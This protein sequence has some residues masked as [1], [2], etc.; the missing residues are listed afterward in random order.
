MTLELDPR[1]L[2][3]KIDTAETPVVPEEPLSFVYEIT[4]QVVTHD[5]DDRETI[6]GKFLV[7][8]VDADAVMAGKYCSY[9][10]MMD[11]RSETVGYYEYLYGRN[12]GVSEELERLLGEEPINQNA[13]ILDRLEIL[14]QYRGKKIAVFVLRRLIE[15]FASSVGIVA[16]K[17]FPLQFEASPEEDDWRQSLK[18]DELPKNETRSVAK[19]RWYYAALGFKRLPKTEYMFL[20]T[21]Y[22]L[23]TLDEILDKLKQTKTGTKR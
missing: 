22:V 11:G 1:F 15:R 23:P 3:L 5:D 6:L 18:L 8:Y 2:W 13:L 9:F 19:L 20:S 16:M 7:F 14:P 17:P 12:D 4:G 21:A 10:E